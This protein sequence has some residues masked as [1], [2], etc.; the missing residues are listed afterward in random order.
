MRACVCV[1]A[2]VCVCMYLCVLI[3]MIVIYMNVIEKVSKVGNR[4]R[5]RPKG[6]LLQH[7]RE[8]EGATSFPGL[9]H[10]TLDTYLILLSVKQGGI[11][12]H[13]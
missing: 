11:K 4:S 8:G 10:Y 1:H 2:R 3:L 7:R 12:Y 13:F 5:E 9:L 6:S